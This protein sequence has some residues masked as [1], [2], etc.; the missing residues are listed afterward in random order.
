MELDKFV[1]FGCWNNTNIKKGKQ[2]GCVKE[3]MD[4]LNSY[5][6]TQEHKPNFLV[7][8]GDNYYPEKNKGADSSKIKIIYPQKLQ[9]GFQYLPDDLPVY[10]ILGNHDL[11]T[12]GKKNNLYIETVETPEPKNECKILQLE[13]ASKKPNVKYEFFKDIMMKNGTLLLMIDT[14]IYEYSADKYLP[15]YNRFFQLNPTDVSRPFLTIDSLR[16]YQNNKI[17]ETI[18]RKLA[19]QPINNI[20]I[21]GHH[22]IIQLKFKESVEVVNDIPFIKPV[23]HRIY[24]TVSRAS[25]GNETKYYYLCS[26]LHLYQ[27]G[28]INYK[29]PDSENVMK[30]K[31]Y[32]V[33][34]GGTE[35]DPPFPPDTNKNVW[36]E[37]INYIVEEEIHKCGFLECVIDVDGN[38][39]FTPNFVVSG[40][41]K[42]MTKKIRKHR[43]SK[44]KN[45]RVKTKRN[46]KNYK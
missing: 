32:I 25:S 15:C 42:R 10:M 3:V 18:E 27:S 26:D 8:S 46:R 14:S 21:I 43:L 37:D 41:K 28:V 34:T 22:P 11:E 9:E 4:M 45:K 33:G 20:I 30:I 19:Q 7:V 31:Q 35:L 38:P 16:E 5:L 1:Q 12:N 17:I 39:F 44:R 6:K 29:I 23:L 40:G 24:D 2:I 13:F 36:L